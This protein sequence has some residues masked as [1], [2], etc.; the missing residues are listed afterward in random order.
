MTPDELRE[1]FL[2]A[3]LTD[4][5]LAWVAAN[6]HIEEFPAE[7]MVVTEGVPATAFYML[8][9]GTLSLSRLVRGQS[10]ELNRTDYR[11]AYVGSVQFYLDEEEPIYRGSVRTITDCSFLVLPA[12]EFGVQF[13]RWFPMASHLL[14]GLIVGGRNRESVIA[15][16]ERLLALG[17]LTAGLTHELNNPAAAA[18]RATASLRE[19]VAGMRHKLALLAGSDLDAVQLKRLTTLQEEIV[20]RVCTVVPLSPLQTSDLEDEI[21]DWLDDHDVQSPGDLPA[22]FVAGGVSVADLDR[23]ESEV[24]I[25][26]LA[27]AV[28]WLGYTVETESLIAEVCDATS[29]ISKLLES[30]KQY[31]QLDRAPHQWIDVHDGLD[32]TLVMFNHRLNSGDPGVTLVKDYDRSLPRVPAYPGE[33]NQVWTNLID[34]ALDAMAGSGTLTVRSTLDGDWVLVEIVDTGPGVPQELRER[35]FEPFFTTKEV[36]EGTGLGLDVSWRIVVNRHDGDLRVV[37]QPG[38]TRFQVR[39]RQTEPGDGID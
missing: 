4:E 30:A 10:M 13:R 26:F 27:S 22:I 3:D 7:T 29:R 23:L 28:H 25:E 31:S 36:G 1:L 32:S 35:I 34:N 11:G 37:S 6:S 20:A 8:L 16:R 24:D 17:R 12:K 21:S 38:D 19:R 9:S 33:L 14:E 15:P 18:S 2:F 39:L 5:Q